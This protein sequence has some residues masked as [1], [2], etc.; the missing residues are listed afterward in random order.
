MPNTA[1]AGLIRKETC[2]QALWHRA[3]AAK[4]ALQNGNRSTAATS[5]FVLKPEPNDICHGKGKSRFHSGNLRAQK[6]VEDMYDQY[7][8]SS[9][10]QKTRMVYGVLEMIHKS[11]GRFLRPA[12]DVLGD[13][14]IG[15]GFVVV[16]DAEAREKVGKFFRKRAAG[17]RR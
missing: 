8:K 11:D 10:S 4:P 12:V 3:N 14:G 15:K 13:E 9:R 5:Q 16:S 7:H 1:E 6:M 2:R 17:T